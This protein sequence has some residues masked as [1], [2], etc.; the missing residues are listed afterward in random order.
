MDRRA[1]LVVVGCG[2]VA[3]CLGIGDGDEP[4]EQE[5]TESGDERQ[6]P[7]V[8]TD[9]QNTEPETSTQAESEQN[10]TESDDVVELERAI[11]RA[12]D[13]YRLAMDEYAQLAPVD[14]PTFI[15]VLPSTDLDS[16]NAREHLN[17]AR[18]ILWYE[19][20]AFAHT[21]ADQQ[22][23]REYRTY[24]QLITKLYR[25]QRGIYRTYTHIEDPSKETIYSSR[26]SSFT[27]ADRDHEEL[28]EQMDDKAIYMDELQ[29]KYDQQD[30]QLTLL[31]RTI[32]GLLN[33]KSRRWVSN[34]STAQLR[35]ARE[36]FRT[37]VDELSDPTSALPADRTDE[38]FL[39]V[40]EAWLRLTDETLQTKAS[41]ID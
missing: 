14:E 8:D 17:R 15:D 10:T 12:E 21:E 41:D 24:D 34:Q 35:F 5:D 9:E 31:E 25:I 40:V 11:K 20:R 32:S 28:G 38:A 33:V 6:L 3:G 1:Y 26:P 13:Q 4:D 39:E 19:A 16:N 36:E 27:T 7:P 29:T 23:V 30:W 37:V 18:S 2:V 22:R